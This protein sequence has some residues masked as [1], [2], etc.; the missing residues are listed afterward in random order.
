MIK[1]SNKNREH[2]T[3]NAKRLKQTWTPYEKISERKTKKLRY[4]EQKQKAKSQLIVGWVEFLDQ[5][6][7][8]NIR[9]FGSVI[10]GPG[11][12]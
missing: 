8:L 3:P 9:E 10:L 12:E 11:Y 5:Q 4:D 1:K 2:Q 6:S 7:I